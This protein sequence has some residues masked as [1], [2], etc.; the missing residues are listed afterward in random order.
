[1][2]QKIKTVVDGKEVETE[3]YTGEE[4]VAQASAKAREIADKEIA[5]AKEAMEAD[6]EAAL[7]EKD[8]SYKKDQEELEKL[9]KKDLNFETLRKSKT[10][11]PEQEAE[12][13]KAADDLK[14]TKDRLDAIEKQPLESAK[15]TFLNSNFGIEDKDQREVFEIFYKKLSLGAKDLKAVNEALVAAF[16]ATTAGAR[17]P[18]FSG[19]MMQTNVSDNYNGEGQ[20]RESEASQEFGTMLGV[21][22]EDKKRFGATIQTGKVNLFSQNP[23][24][25]QD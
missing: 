6:K 12:A 24:K 20:G 11:T 7:L 14:S 3:V 9:R 23:P 4:L 2:P 1:M 10:L 25:K 18:S 16:N 22:A 17:K 21:S 5:D 13:K 19:R 15:E 8:E